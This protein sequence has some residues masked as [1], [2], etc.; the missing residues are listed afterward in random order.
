M[1]GSK[2]PP[3]IPWGSYGIQP[4]DPWVPLWDPIVPPGDPRVPLWIPGVIFIHPRDPWGDHHTPQG[5]LGSSSYT[6]GVPGVLYIYMYIYMHIYI[7]FFFF[8][9]SLSAPSDRADFTRTPEN[10]D[11]VR[12]CI[13]LCLPCLAAVPS[14]I[15]DQCAC[16]WSVA[17]RS[18]TFPTSLC[19]VARHDR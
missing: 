13:K 1:G 4:R 19:G 6:P 16:V 5:S 9:K 14:P 12:L 2:V 8:I 18:I 11:S 10:V 3:G 17:L 7:Y 15:V